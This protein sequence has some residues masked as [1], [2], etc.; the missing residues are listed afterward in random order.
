[1]AV[2]AHFGVSVFTER[3]Q[4]R[5]NGLHQFFGSDLARNAFVGARLNVHSRDAVVLVAVVPG[6]DGAPGEGAGMAILVAELHLGDLADAL[7]AGFAFGGVERAEDPH[8]QV[9]RR[10]LHGL[11]PP[12]LYFERGCWCG[13]NCRR[14]AFS[15]QSYAVL[16]KN[17]G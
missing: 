17:S 11:L 5:I 4:R 15:L 1:M 6:L 10:V 7:V 12:V 14:R 2:D 8:L 3:R 9:G 16:L 13:E